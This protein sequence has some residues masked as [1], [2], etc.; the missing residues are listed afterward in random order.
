MDKEFPD[1]AFTQL[2]IEVYH[3]IYSSPR[4]IRKRRILH[5][6]P[7]QVI[8]KIAFLTVLHDQVQVLRVHETVDVLGDVAMFDFLHEFG[9]FTGFS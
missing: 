4:A 3:P 1:T 2:E 5:H 7:T 8:R 9:L 6:T